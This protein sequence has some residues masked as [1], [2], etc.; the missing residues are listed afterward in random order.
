MFYPFL[1][2]FSFFAGRLAQ[3]KWKYFRKRAI[4]SMNKSFPENSGFAN[5]LSRIIHPTHFIPLHKLAFTSIS[6]LLCDMDLPCISE[7]AYGCVY[8]RWSLTPGF[9][10]H[11]GVISS[12]NHETTCTLSGIDSR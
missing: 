5:N 2:L 11:D 4:P 10:A 7:V 8:R 3:R 12:S 9:G 6:K 1:R